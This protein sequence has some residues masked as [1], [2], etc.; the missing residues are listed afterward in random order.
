[1]K[2]TLRF[3]AFISLASFLA[4]PVNAMPIASG[5]CDLTCTSMITGAVKAH[6]WVVGS[7]TFCELFPNAVGMRAHLWSRN[8]PNGFVSAAVPFSTWYDSTNNCQLVYSGNTPPVPNLN[9]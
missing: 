4:G 7:G 3:S 1:M 6:V 2:K 5:R 9:N 8:E